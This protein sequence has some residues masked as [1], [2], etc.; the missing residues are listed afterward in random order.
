M[1]TGSGSCTGARMGLTTTIIVEV[2]KALFVSL[3]VL[4]SQLSGFQV[5]RAALP[6]L[7]VVKSNL[8]GL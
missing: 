2:G 3:T 6:Q 7:W 1:S 5:E 4:L 8:Q